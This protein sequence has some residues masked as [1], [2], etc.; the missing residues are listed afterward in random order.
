MKALLCA[1]EQERLEAL[2][3]YRILDTPPERA[4]D[5]LSA[6]VAYVC[7]VPIAMVSRVD[8]ERQWFKSKFG[9]E[10]TET[11]QDVCFCAHAILQDDLPVV[12]DTHL[13]ARF[14]TNLPLLP[15]TMTPLHPDHFNH[16]GA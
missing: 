16:Q 13:N 8:S 2:R 10:A 3:Q 11:S 4:I 15:G 12:L 6:L 9:L 1:R 7:D 5:D 14:A